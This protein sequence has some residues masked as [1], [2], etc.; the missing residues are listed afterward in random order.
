MVIVC[1]SS[2]A[3]TT[4]P[5]SVCAAKPR[6]I[7]SS[8]TISWRSVSSRELSSGYSLQ[9]GHHEP[10][11][12]GQQPRA[13]VGRRPAALA[14]RASS[15]VA[16]TS[17]Q[18]VASGISARLRDSAAET[19][20]RN[21]FS[22]VRRSPDA[23]AGRRGRAT[24]GDRGCAAPAT[25]GAP[26]DGALDV[27]AG[28]RPPRPVPSSACR[29]SPRSRASR[30]TSGEITSGTA[31]GPA[32]RRAADAGGRAARSRPG[33]AAGQDRGAG[34]AGAGA[35]RRRTPRACRS[36]SA[37]C[38]SRPSPPRGRPRLPGRSPRRD[39][40]ATG[41]GSDRQRGTVIS[42]LPTSSVWPV[43]RRAAGDDPAG[44]RGGHLDH[45]LGGLDLDDRL[46]DGDDV[47]HGDEPARR[48]RPR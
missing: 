35:V 11:E 31:A 24:R 16:S 1:A 19:A 17:T 42:G 38:R 13:R 27:A 47:A 12:V 25:V 45:G 34:A 32:P 7:A 2:T 43:G 5:R 23:A 29:S 20:L 3:G 10:R 8:S 14:Q 15:A 37:R 6:L 41:A 36:R 18:T 21:P 9:P 44:V 28:D 4:R 40:A 30:R 22:G 26:G 48:S 33:A 39:G 46:V